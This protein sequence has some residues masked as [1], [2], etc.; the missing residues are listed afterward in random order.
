MSN[1]KKDLLLCFLLEDYC[2]HN[3]FDFNILFNKLKNE[4]L[5]DINYQLSDTPKILNNLIQQ[6]NTSQEIIPDSFNRINN[7]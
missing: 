1:I 4:N 5:I 2:K 6:S 7:E 3:N